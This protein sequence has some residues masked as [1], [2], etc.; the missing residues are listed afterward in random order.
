MTPPKALDPNISHLIYHF[1]LYNL[2]ILISR[3]LSIY[4]QAQYLNISHLIQI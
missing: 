3:N 2:D 1:Q 4:N